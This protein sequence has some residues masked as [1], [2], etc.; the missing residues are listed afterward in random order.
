MQHH[1]ALCQLPF[2]LSCAVATAPPLVF[3][4]TSYL[5]NHLPLWPVVLPTARQ[6]GDISTF[7]KWRDLAAHRDQ[8]RVLSGAKAR[9]GG[10]S[11]PNAPP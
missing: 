5:F 4:R 8:W 7:T 2:Q 3:V 6:H 11:A 10:V 9:A 1:D